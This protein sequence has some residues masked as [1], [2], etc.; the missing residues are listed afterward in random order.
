MDFN[1][2]KQAIGANSV[3][4]EGVV[5]QPVDSDVTLPD[6]CPDILR[7][8]KCTITPRITGVQTAG[9]RVNIDGNALVRILYV[10]EGSK[11]RCY[12]QTY[13]F[14]KHVE[15]SNLTDDSCVCVK[16]RTDY[17]NCRAV[18]QRRTDIHGMITISIRATEKRD[19][20]IITGAQ[21]AGIQLRCKTLNMLSSIAELEKPFPMSEVVEVGQSN[22][23]V[24]QII[25]SDALAFID[26]VKTI[27]NKILIKGELVVS[28]LYYADTPDAQLSTFTHSMPISQII[29]VEGVSE[30]SLVDA[31]LHVTSLDISTKADSAGE[32]NLLDISARICAVIKADNEIEHP[33]INDAYSTEYEMN[34]ERKMFDYI[35]LIEKFKDSFVSKDTMDFSATGITEVL[36]EWHG[37]VT[38]AAILRDNELIISGCV[39]VHVLYLDKDGQQSYAERQVDY[40][41]KRAVRENISKLVCNPSVM[42]TADNYNLSS[43]NRVEIKIEFLVYASILSQESEMLIADI[44]PLENQLLKTKSAL[45][46]YFSDVGE[47]VWDIA[48]KYNTTVDSVKSENNIKDDV[49]P[50]KIMLL[51]PSV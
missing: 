25:R 29:E 23:P 13:P 39:T 46:I 16:A 11:L 40:E 2:D 22:P 5:E 19:D 8:L 51:I 9:D 32:M 28:I 18:S 14:S 41:Y 44:Q 38:A 6:Y 7:I 27:N 20:D 15:I 33:V 12:E 36:N 37:D 47:S 17:A 4:F 26:D 42:V 43:E 34:F 48:R 31:R 3:I 21:G 50:E 24:A 30:N 35:H 45:T 10:S 1:L 49:I